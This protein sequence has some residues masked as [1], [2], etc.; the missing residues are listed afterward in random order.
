MTTFSTNTAITTPAAK[1]DVA[2]TFARL[3]TAL[4]PAPK[5]AEDLL[6]AAQRREDAR[7]RV[8]HL[9]R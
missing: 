4:R 7:A 2:K 3:I 6:A 1:I 9:L 8:D 5:T